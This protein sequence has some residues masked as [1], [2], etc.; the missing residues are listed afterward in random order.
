[1]DVVLAGHRPI[2]LYERSG[3]RIA[4]VCTCALSIL[5][6]KHQDIQEH[7]T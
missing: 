5:S 4:A 3:G 2:P 1:M 7:Q 6:A